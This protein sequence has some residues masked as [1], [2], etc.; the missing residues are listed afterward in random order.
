MK[1]IFLFLFVINILQHTN[2][3]L[4]IA[5]L[6]AYYPFSGDAKDLS[7]NGN[8]GSI[9]G[10]TLTNDRFG[11]EKSAYYFDGLSNYIL[12]SL[13][14][15][16]DTH[17]RSFTFWAK[18]EN[19]TEASSNY[20][21]SYG[22][23]SEG[24]A[25]MGFVDCH[26]S[27]FGAEVSDGTKYIPHPSICSTWLHY[28]IVLA[29]SL[30]PLLSDV[31]IYLNGT[32]VNNAEYY[33]QNKPILTQ[34]G[35]SLNIGRNF[36][37]DLEGNSY[38]KGSIDEMRIYNRALSDAEIKTIATEEV[39]TEIYNIQSEFGLVKIFPN[40]SSNSITISINNPSE[41]FTINI[42]NQQSEIIHSEIINESI[43]QVQLS[44]FKPGLYL[45]Q[46]VDLN[47]NILETKKLVIN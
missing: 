44:K 23:A 32:L 3:Q 9:V 4:P 42:I 43:F 40:P 28:A 13:V 37:Q 5:G 36:Y 30:Y 25:F 38:Y 45:I 11:K 18:A 31:K 12:T 29:P 22:K 19:N 21:F 46:I 47:K 35:N 1:K 8:D 27:V 14:P 20:V 7:G 39:V 16:L 26:S 15:P 41:N 34:P 24:A 17:E 10:A 33:N 6:I 2:A